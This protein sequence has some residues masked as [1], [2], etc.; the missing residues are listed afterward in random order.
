MRTNIKAFGYKNIWILILVM[1]LFASCLQRKD[2]IYLRNEK[3]SVPIP[4]YN[5]YKLRPQDIVFVNITSSD[6]NLQQMFGNL[7]EDR[8]YALNER[9]L[10]ISGYIVDADSTIRLPYLG[11]FK[12]GGLTVNQLQDAIQKSLNDMVI[13]TYVNVRLVNFKVTLLG[14][15]ERPGVY[16]IA[17][18]NATIFDA[19]A[20]GGDISKSGNRKQVKIVREDGSKIENYIVDLSDV[21]VLTS[22][23]FYVYPNDVIMIEPTRHKILLE[24]LPLYT[25]FLSTITTFLLIWN[26]LGKN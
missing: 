2:L 14:E 18:P 5:E 22:P 26:V 24:N 25:V 20:L 15:F 10:A 13:D 12:A 4:A 7:V 1:I 11:Q 21:K 17:Q 19:I 16:Y 23:A 3:I 9:N 6:R 8:V